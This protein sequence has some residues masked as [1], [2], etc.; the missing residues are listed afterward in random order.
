MRAITARLIRL[1]GGLR[2]RQH[3]LTGASHVPLYGL[4]VANAHEDAP[5]PRR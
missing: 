4:L 3:R 5:R 2:E 1:L